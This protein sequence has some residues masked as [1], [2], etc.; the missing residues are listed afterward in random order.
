MMK[1]K[2]GFVFGMLIVIAVLSYALTSVY[3]TNSKGNKTEDNI[4][5]VTSFYPVYIAA[6]NVMDGAE[7]VTLENLSEPQTGCLHDYQLTPAD[8]KLL[9]SADVFLV[10]GGG[11][12]SFLADVAEAYENLEIK[13]VTDGIDFIE[14]EEETNAHVWMD[15]DNYLIEVENICDLMSEIDPDNK[16]IY[17]SNRDAYMESLN[18]LVEEKEELGSAVSE[19]GMSAALLQESFVYLC[20]TLGVDVVYTMDLDEERQVSAGEVADTMAAVN[21]NDG[22]VIF[23]DELYGADL[24][25]TVS[26]ETGATVCIIDPCVR[27]DYEKDSYI[28]AMTA[29]FSAVR[30]A[31][32]K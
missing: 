26:K 23:T 22:A 16:E 6:M 12:E 7:N 27:G 14:D 4:K 1:N 15:I 5:V 30:E 9:E 11:I 19:N 8:M 2:Y 29:N 10:N 28:N 18:E 20:E 32:L 24:A 13:Y 25:E 3:V 17:E 21:D 31:L